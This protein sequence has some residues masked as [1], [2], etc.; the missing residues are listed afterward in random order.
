L[1]LREGPSLYRRSNPTHQP[2][3]WEQAPCEFAVE[4]QPG[5]DVRVWIAYPD[6]PDL[7]DVYWSSLIE[8]KIG[9]IPIPTPNQ[10]LTNNPAFPDP[11]EWRYLLQMNTKDNEG[12]DDPF[13]IN[14]ATDGV[15]YAF[16]SHDGKRGMFLWSR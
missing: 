1:P 14:F 9:G 11:T 13:F 7:K 12:A 5:D 15:G 4:L 6:D 10:M 16:I 8:D 3:Q 2:G